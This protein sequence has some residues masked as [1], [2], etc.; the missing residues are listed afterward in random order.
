MNN[1]RNIRKRNGYTIKQLH[2]MTGLPIRSL[3]DWDAEKRQIQ[4]YHRIKLLARV[5]DCDMDELMTKEEKCVYG[6]KNAV[7]ELTQEE[8]GV[9]IEVVSWDDEF[10]M[11]F[12]TIIPRETALELLDQIKGNDLVDVEPFFDGLKH[13]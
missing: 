5:L 9:H 11:L 4:S 2:E 8:D 1:L 3:E 13:P 6:G 10:K 7:I 12:K